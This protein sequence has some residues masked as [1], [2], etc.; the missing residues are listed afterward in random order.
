MT[1]VKPGER[2]SHYKLLPVRLPDETLAAIKAISRT[3]DRPAWRVIVDAIAAYLGDADGL[4]ERDR[5]LAHGLLRRT[6]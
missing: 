2:S 3:V 5:R 6:E 4:P 1:G